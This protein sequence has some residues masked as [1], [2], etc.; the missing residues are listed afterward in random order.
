MEDLGDGEDELAGRGTGEINLPGG[1]PLR[2]SPLFGRPANAGSG[3]AV[4]F[5]T[6][7]FLRGGLLWACG[8]DPNPWGTAA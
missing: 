4:Q 5:E 8:R 6:W 7:K 2:A 1:Q 3:F